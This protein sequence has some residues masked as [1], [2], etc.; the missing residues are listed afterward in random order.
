MPQKEEILWDIL[1]LM[2]GHAASWTSTFGE[3]EPVTHTYKN[4]YGITQLKG[5]LI[6]KYLPDDIEDTIYFMW[7]REYLQK[8]GQ[9]MLNPNI[10]YSLQDKALSVIEQNKL[11]KEE[12]IAFRESLWE[13]KP[14][15]WGMGINLP[16]FIRRIKKKITN[17]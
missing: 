4:S 7:N 10:L 2:H 5:K 1:R 9:G 12:E 11:P 3:K 16:E 13:I 17:K 6:L 15:L 14:K 8:H